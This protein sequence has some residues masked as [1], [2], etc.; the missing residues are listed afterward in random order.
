MSNDAYAVAA[1]LV[2]GIAF[3]I[4]DI[5]SGSTSTN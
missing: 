3:I 1:G 5:I 4:S 2:V